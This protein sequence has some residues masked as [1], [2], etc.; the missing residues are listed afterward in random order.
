V[1]AGERPER[2]LR[3]PKILLDKFW[4]PPK[5][6]EELAARP[7]GRAVDLQHGVGSQKKEKEK[8]KCEC[9]QLL[10]D[11]T[12]CTVQYMFSNLEA[13]RQPLYTDRVGKPQ[14]QETHFGLLGPCHAIGHI[15]PPCQKKLPG[16]SQPK[17]PAV[18]S[19]RHWDHTCTNADK[20]RSGKPLL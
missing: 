5:A 12:D 13:T 19:P 1:G 11:H 18:P 3:H 16:G 9:G 2:R 20:V 7:H 15:H 17:G 6:A 4:R 10:K 8:E 14:D